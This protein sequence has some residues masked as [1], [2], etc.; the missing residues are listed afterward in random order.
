MPKVVDHDERRAVIAE[1]LLR[2]AAEQ[3]AEAVS[4][5]HVAAEAGVSTGM[6]QHYFGTR[7]ELMAFAMAQV[8]R[9]VQE[10]LARDPA[11]GGPREAIRS[12]FLAMLPVDPDRERE[13]HVALAFFA[14]VAIRPEL[15]RELRE[16]AVGLR[17]HLAGQI[18]DAGSRMPPEA[19][20]IG[21]LALAD[22]LGVQVVTGMLSAEEAVAALDAQLDVIF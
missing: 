4:L 16:G 19:A 20:A 15:A 17:A 22:G 3:G 6:V 7:D 14:H 9:H 10:R 13:A 12:L 21:L 5:R 11:P 1:A 2:V 18:R 8:S